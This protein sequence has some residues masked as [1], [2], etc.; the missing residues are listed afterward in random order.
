MRI[1]YFGSGQFG[2][3]CLEAIVSSGHE[4]A[5]VFTQPARPA[6]RHRELKPTD[7]TLWCREK[8]VSCVE[9]ED[10]NTPEYADQIKK[11]NADLLVVI[12]F[13]Q[14]VA[15]HIVDLFPKGAINVHGSLLP[16]YRG[17]APIH[18]A[19]I[20]GESET[21]I[22]IITLADRMDAGQ[23]LAQASTSITP[24]DDFQ[25]LHDRLARLSVPLLMQTITTI[26]KGTAVYRPQDKKL[27]TQAPKLK[28]EHGFIDWSKSAS[29]IVNQIRGLWPWP[30]AAAVFVSA[31][32]GKSWRA[33]IAKIAVIETPADSNQVCGMLDDNLNVICGQGRLKIITLKPAGSG[34]MDFQAFVNGRHGGKGDLFLPLDMVIRNFA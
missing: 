17:A 33:I 7:V 22:S 24:E 32:T 5:A 34:L 20:N 25:T 4:L 1:L 21:G 11:Y 3:S 19:I 10:I 28:K 30:G 27:V 16:R 31:K 13:G 14:K 18:W 2:V 12:A 29:D 8:N 6:G 15:K 9:A 26:E 23:I